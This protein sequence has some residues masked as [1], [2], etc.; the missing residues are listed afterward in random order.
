MIYFFEGVARAKGA[1]GITHHFVDEVRADS[2]DA[3]VLKLYD[4]WEH[5]RITHHT[6]HNEVNK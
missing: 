4:K 5:I 2:Y 1:I 6:E 3:A